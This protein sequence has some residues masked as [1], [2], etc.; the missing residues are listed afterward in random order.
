MTP[1]DQLDAEIRELK[2]LAKPSAMP[3]NRQPRKISRPPYTTVS[4]GPVT[5]YWARKL[6]PEREPMP[7]NARARR[8]RRR[9]SNGCHV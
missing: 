4:P 8:L 1:N 9:N 3:R 6:A 7:D 5:P 2:A